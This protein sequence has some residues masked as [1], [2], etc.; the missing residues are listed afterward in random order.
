MNDANDNRVPIRTM[1][2]LAIGFLGLPNSFLWPYI[3]ATGR[4]TKKAGHTRL[5]IDRP[6]RVPTGSETLRHPFTGWPLTIR[7][8]ARLM[9]W[10]DSFLFS[11]QGIEINRQ[12]ITKLVK[13][14]GRA[15]PSEFPRYLIPQLQ[16]HIER[17]M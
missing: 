17:R 6:S 13:L 4:T 2:E 11:G 1:T 9:G 16:N 8:R 7:E 15:V 12:N 14:T 10:P 5:A 3:T